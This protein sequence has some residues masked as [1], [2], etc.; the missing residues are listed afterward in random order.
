MAR[1]SERQL[2][3]LRL[4]HIGFVFQRF[5]LLP[6]L[7]AQENVMLP[8]QLAGLPAA[9]QR[10]RAIELLSWVGLSHRLSHK[11]R[12][13]SAGENQR[14]GIARALA[15]KPLLLLADEAT[16]NLDTRT[17]HEIVQLFQRVNCEHGITI[18]L[19]THNPEVAQAARRQF[20][21]VDG[22][23]KETGG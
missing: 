23:L 17:S 5:N 14:V 22:R 13:L 12:E 11:S 19:V 8:M 20:R 6:I 10:R 2:D 1:L 21:M 3:D 7:S 18:V 15:N 4:R 9:E 16:G